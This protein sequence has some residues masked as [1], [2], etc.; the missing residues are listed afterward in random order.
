MKYYS[1][2]FDELS[3][4]DRSKFIKGSIIPRPI[5]WITTLNEDGSVNL[6]PFSYFNLLN[7]STVMVSFFRPEKDVRVADPVAP[8]KN[9]VAPSKHLVAPSKH[10]KDTPLKD[11]PR[12]ILRTGEAVIQIPSRSLIAQVDLSSA[13]LPYGESELLASH[14]STVSSTRVKVPG[15]AE[16]LIR[17]EVTL[18]QHVEIPFADNSGIESDLILMRVV[19][20]HFAESV[21][22]PDKHYILADKLDPLSRLGGPDYAGIDQVK[23]FKRAF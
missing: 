7:T 11:T 5:A 18:Y 20:A 15:V 9:L 2:S 22:D 12:N 8:S 10:L 1:F 14:L 4:K 23:D 19:E 6:A 3:A 21:F 13:P 17:L 16:A